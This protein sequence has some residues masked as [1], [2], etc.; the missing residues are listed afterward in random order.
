VE[1]TCLQDRCQE[2]LSKVKEEMITLVNFINYQINEMVSYISTKN[3]SDDLFERGL[4][5]M[6]LKKQIVHEKYLL[7]LK[8]SWKHIIDI[9]VSDNSEL[10]FLSTHHEELETFWLHECD[11]CDD[12]D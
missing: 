11:C 4:L 2:E 1:L 9:P 8:D 5:C 12:I 3:V 6:M 10:P 7:S